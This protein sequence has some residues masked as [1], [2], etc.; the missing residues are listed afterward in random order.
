[1]FTGS[2]PKWQILP[3]PPPTGTVQRLSLSAVQ[4]AVM[5]GADVRYSPPL[6]L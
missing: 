2:L 3:T 6:K 1:M 5:I 4:L